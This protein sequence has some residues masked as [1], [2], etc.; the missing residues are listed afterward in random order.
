MRKVLFDLK[1]CL[2]VRLT[3]RKADLE[4]ELRPKCRGE[5]VLLLHVTI[6]CKEA[7]VYFIAMTKL[8]RLLSRYIC[9]V[10]MVFGVDLF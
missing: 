4:D 3:Y 10:I 7:S 8:L 5:L 6:L 1:H 2:L 9:S